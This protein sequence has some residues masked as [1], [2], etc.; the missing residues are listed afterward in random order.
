MRRA[1]SALAL[2]F[3]VSTHASAQDPATSNPPAKPGDSP[4]SEYYV[5]APPNGSPGSV[6]PVPPPP[7]SVPEPPGPPPAPPSNEQ[8]PIVEPPT[9]EYYPENEGV[10]EPPPPPERHHVA[11]KTALWLGVRAG[12]FVPFGN[13]WARCTNCNSANTNQFATLEGVHWSDYASAGPMFEL[14][15]GA[16]LSRNYAVFALWER[17]ELGGGSGDSGP[18]A[19]AG[20]ASHGDT[21]FW[22]VGIRATSDADHIGFVT[23]LA[24]GYRRARSTWDDG[25]ELQLTDAPFEARLGLGADFRLNPYITLSPMFTLGVGSFG[26]VERVSNGISSDETGPVDQADGHAWAT[27]TVGGYFDLF[28]SQR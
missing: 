14:D 15:A 10:F 1:A 2:I 26:K 4:P 11:P 27:F 8:S 16:R 21:D 19:I 13:L 6:A 3:S 18:N 28:G 12:V 9:P 25:S 5:E 20:K 23:E 7:S 22:G 24:V 17:A